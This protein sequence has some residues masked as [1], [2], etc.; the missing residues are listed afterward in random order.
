[1][2]PVEET[3]EVEASAEPLA[4]WTEGIYHGPGRKEQ[5]ISLSH[6]PIP[7]F[8]WPAMKMDLPLAPGV[9]LPELTGEA[10]IR[11]ELERLD[12]ITYQ[13]L[14]VE[15]LPGDGTQ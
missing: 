7:E 3:G 14:A 1:M 13:I 11:F 12:E 4:V 10:P 15:A 6:Q 8:G 2:T 5:T 9:A